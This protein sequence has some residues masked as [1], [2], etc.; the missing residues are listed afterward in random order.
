MVILCFDTFKPYFVN[1]KTN[2]TSLGIHF[3]NPHPLN[4]HTHIIYE[5]NL[6]DEGQI[7]YN[8]PS[9]PHQVKTQYLQF[10]ISCKLLSFT[11]KD[12]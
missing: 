9:M 2:D 7:L 3:C 8:P 1:Y 5:G 6:L 11:M 12:S 10:Q 4:T